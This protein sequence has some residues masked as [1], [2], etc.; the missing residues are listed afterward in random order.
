MKNATI[1][2]PRKAASFNYVA[3]AARLQGAIVQADNASAAILATIIELRGHAD[4]D[5]AREIFTAA[6]VAATAELR[7][8]EPE[9]LA[10]DVVVRA[11]VAD[12]MAVFGAPELPEGMTTR[13]VQGAAKAC[14][15][16][17]KPANENDG[18]KAKRA[19]RTPAGGKGE[20]LSPLEALAISLELLRTEAGKVK[21]KSK[22]AKALDL[23]GDLVDL[24]DELK[25]ILG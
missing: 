20:Q 14:R 18:E 24:A 5:K 19:P 1:R 2:T 8:V 22:Q 12:C 6:Y 4:A 11:R 21:A 3:Y 25:A 15:A 13:S 17:G 10:K 7:G 9:T 23:I 16:V